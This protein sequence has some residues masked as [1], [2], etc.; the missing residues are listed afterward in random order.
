[1]TKVIEA[2]HRDVL[3]D[4]DQ[5]TAFEVFTADMTSWWPSDHHIGAAPIHD[6]VIE[7]WVGAGGLC[8]RTFRLALE[9]APAGTS[10]HA[11]ADKGDPVRDI[12]TVIGRRLGLPVDAVPSETYGPLG[13]IFAID[14]PS[15]SA[16]TRP[17]LGW[18][19]TH[20]SLLA[21]LEKV[22]PAE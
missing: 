16:H 1:M 14:Q 5:A 21:D 2:I 3:V 15:S 8:G 19:P 7:P 4:V 9:L 13:P 17:T 18:Q 11:V 10:W 6:V 12:A 22:Q 20:L